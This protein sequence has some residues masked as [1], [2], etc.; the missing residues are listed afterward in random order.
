MND[1]QEEIILSICIPTYNRKEFLEK[2]VKSVLAV[3][4]PQIEIMISDNCSSDDTENY[5][6]N[7]VSEN[8]QIKYIRNST[9]IGPDG[10]FL[11]LLQK[12]NGKYI[13]ILSDDDEVRCADIDNFLLFLSKNDFS[14]GEFYAVVKGRESTVPVKANKIYKDSEICDFIKEHGIFLT[15]VSSL[16]FSREAFLKIENPERF[17]NT[18]LL[19][20]HLA[21]ETLKSGGAADIFDYFISA[22]QNTSGGYNFYEV[23]IKNWRSVLFETMRNV[24]IPKRFL[25][26]QFARDL[27]FPFP[28][29]VKEKAIGINFVTKPKWRYFKYSFCY[30]YGIFVILPILLMP[31]FMVR[32]LYFIYCK[33]KHKGKSE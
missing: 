22:T 20:T 11:Q 17:L 1:L 16:L 31:K 18:N 33:I 24:G 6:R 25:R 15:F 8:P 21:A 10:N 5:C 27:R 14:L 13:Q 3:Y 19:Q 4:R 30:P 23:F 12:A 7:L 28:Y 9:N 2:A 29:L 26:Q 32:F